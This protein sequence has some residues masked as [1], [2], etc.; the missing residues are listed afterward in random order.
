MKRLG[1]IIFICGVALVVVGVREMKLSSAARAEPSDL[2]CAQL[3]KDGPGDNVHVRLSDFIMYDNAAVIVTSKRSKRWKHAWVPAVPT[4]GPWFNS[5][6]AKMQTGDF[7]PATVQPPRD[8][9]VLVKTS[10]VHDEMELMRFLESD[11]LTGMVINGVDSIDSKER[12]EI[13]TE[14][15]GVNLSSAYILDC[16]RTP[17]SGGK[18]TGMFAGGAVLCA[19]P[20]VLMVRRKRSG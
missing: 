15:P 17:A 20:L 6:K 11:S 2:T 10:K 9:I 16:G 18:I 19:L 7:D 13:E 5:M 1:L 4:D 8:S 14:L 12:R 3:A